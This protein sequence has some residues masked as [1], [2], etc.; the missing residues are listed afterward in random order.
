MDLKRVVI[1]GIGMISPVGLNTATTWKNIVNG[2]SGSDLITLFDTT[3]FK[4]KFACEVK[5]Y[6]PNDYFDRNEIKKMDRFSQ[7]AMIAADEA[8]KNANLDLPNLDKTR[9]GVVWASGIGGIQTITDELKQYVLGNF[10][11]RISPFF[12]PRIITDIAAGHISIKHGLM[13]PNYCTVSACASSTNAVIDAYNLIRLGM[14]DVIVSGGS[15]SAVSEMGIGGFQSMKALSVN[16]EEYKTASRP[17]CATRS[18]FV[19]GEGGCSL[20]IE[21]YEFAKKRGAKILAEIVG[22]GL[23]ADGYHIV[24]PHPEGLGAALVME[25]AL[26]QAE[27]SSDKIDYIN[28]HGTSTPLGDISELIAINKVFGDDAFKTNISSTKSMVGHLLGAAGA[29]ELAFCVLAINDSIVPPTINHQVWDE[30]IDKRFNLT[31]NTAQK[32]NITYALSNTFG[33]GGHNTSVI[34]KKAE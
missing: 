12:I 17:F 26:K 8:I 20:I 16:N 22:C 13:G 3:L 5:G 28:V 11:P 1:T 25:N 19:M 32:R 4:V 7:F 33:F 31:L 14:A 29:I 30:N 6:S 15:E 2:V 23:S 27:I 10:E 34:V 18:G 9:I 24:A 21:D